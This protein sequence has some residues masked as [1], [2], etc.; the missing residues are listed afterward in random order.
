MITADT[1]L[2]QMQTESYRTRKHKEF[3]KLYAL[4]IFRRGAAVGKC[5]PMESS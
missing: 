1:M 3:V 2:K 4:F 5:H